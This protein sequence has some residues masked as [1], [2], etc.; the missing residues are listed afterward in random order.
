MNYFE[1]RAK[2]VVKV[3][4]ILEPVHLSLAEVADQHVL[5]SIDRRIKEIGERADMPLL[6]HD[7]RATFGNR[8]WKRGTDIAI[9]DKL[10]GHESSDQTFRAYIGLSQE[11]QR[12]VQDSL[13]PQ[14]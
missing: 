9:I 14:E 3:A 10:M 12:R 7:L 5:V 8:H 4:A 6:S 1:L 13:G 11:D 2:R